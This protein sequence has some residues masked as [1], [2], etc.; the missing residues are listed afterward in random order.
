M[1]DST[2]NFLS[3]Y[4]LPKSIT[5]K[6]QLMSIIVTYYEQ[7]LGDYVTTWVCSN[8]M[9]IMAGMKAKKFNL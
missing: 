5:V 6:P 7:V 4:T 2:Y 8:C 9:Y 3:C 1:C